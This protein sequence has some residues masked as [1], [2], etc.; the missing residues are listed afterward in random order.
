[1]SL[2]TSYSEGSSSLRTEIGIGFPGQPLAK[3]AI[4]LRLIAQ[5]QVTWVKVERLKAEAC[6]MLWLI[7]L[8]DRASLRMDEVAGQRSWALRGLL[9]GVASKS[10]E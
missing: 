4:C 9:G 7:D 1:L 6:E 5:R 10:E 2:A 3:T 8:N